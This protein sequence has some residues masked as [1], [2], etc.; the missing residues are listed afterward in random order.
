MFLGS[1][2]YVP[3]PYEHMFVGLRTYVHENTVPLGTQRHHASRTLYIIYI[4]YFSLCACV[5]L[6]KDAKTLETLE[7]L[8]R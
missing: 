3:T 1:R 4:D 8:L 6:K 5:F 2:T 7:A